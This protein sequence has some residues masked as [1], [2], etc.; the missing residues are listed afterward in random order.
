MLCPSDATAQFP[1]ELTGRVSD[2]VTGLPVELALIEVLGTNGMALSDASGAFHIRG[3]EPGRHRLRISRLG[4]EPQVRTVEIHNGRTAWLAVKLGVRPVAVDELAVEAWND[5]TPGRL[6]MSRPQIEAAGDLTAAGLLDGWAGLVVQ[7]RGAGGRQTVSIRGGSADEV[8]VLLDGAPLNDPLTGEADLSTV[9][10]SQIESIEVLK[11]SQ[12]AT[13]GPRAVAG[14]VLI[15]SRASAAPLRLALE[16]GSLGYWSG[17]AETGG[18]A[19]GWEWS[20]GVRAR[21][22]DG[23]F[24]FARPDELGGGRSTRLNTDNEELSAFVAADGGAAGGRLRLR[25]GFLDLDRGIPGPSFLPTTTAREEL[26][27]WRGQAAW[28]R[29]G[30]LWRLSTRLH[31]VWQSARFHDSEPPVG[32][33]YDSHSDALALG[34]RLAT[35]LAPEAGPVR[36]LSGGFELRGQRYESAALGAG[37]PDGRLDFGIFL[38][39]ELAPDPASRT[40]LVAALRLDRDDL[41]DRFHLT[42]ELG[43]HTGIGPATFRVR[44]AASY[45]P[46]TFGDQFFREGVAVQPN[47]DLRAERVPDEWTVA[48]DL[49]GRIGSEATGGLSVEGYIADVRDMIIWAPDFRFVWS[50]RNFHVERRGVDVQARIA[51]PLHQIELDGSYSLARATY[52]RDDDV[53]VLYR[54]R[55]SAALSFAWRPGSWDVR[56]EA[57]FVGTRYPVPARLNALDPYWSVDLRVRHRFDME[58][59][60]LTA[61]LVVDRLLDTEASLIYGYPEPGRVL[62]FELAASPQLTKMNEAKGEGR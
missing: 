23:S 45:S 1:G 55:H 53:Q 9:P 44:H 7:R 15:E 42:H 3:L 56:G 13:Y 5:A 47:P 52:D 10:A 16:T 58:A 51:F 18:G 19:L 57:R 21:I 38:G 29:G 60:R 32:L 33:P 31:G 43:L 25:G 8:L 11:G 12:T 24:E 40:R 39:G 14:V 50:P 59:W 62:R 41:G 34:A 27:R 46:P 54:P 36:S 49:S 20:A 48:V 28:E 26:S 37:A 6:T 61:A 30:H 22:A 17:S 4:Y 2:A 35:E